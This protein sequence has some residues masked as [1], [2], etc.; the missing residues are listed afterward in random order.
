MIKKMTRQP[1]TSMYV[2]QGKRNGEI[3]EFV[4]YIKDA[5]RYPPMSAYHWYSEAGVP[6]SD[7]PKRRIAVDNLQSY[8]AFLE[9]E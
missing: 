3:S 4:A 9:S 1:L 6:L 7:E 2:A 5:R 8:R